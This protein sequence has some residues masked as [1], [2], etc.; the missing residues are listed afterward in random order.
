MGKYV[1][2]VQSRKN[3]GDKMIDRNRKVRKNS[4]VEVNEENKNDIHILC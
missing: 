4:S 1:Y 2:G 3:F